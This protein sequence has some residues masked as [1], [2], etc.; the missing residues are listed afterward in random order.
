MTRRGAREGSIRQR[1]D[2]RWEA[3]YPGPDGNRRSVYGATRR[4]AQERLRDALASA[5][6]GLPVVDGRLTTGAY[7]E[8]WVAAART[9]V[10]PATASSYAATVKLYLVPELGRVP[11]A[12]LGPEHVTSMLTRLSARKL[13]VRQAPDKAAGAPDRWEAAWRG[14]DGGL[15]SVAA[16]T[17]AEAATL[18][19]AA[20]A[21]DGGGTQPV[22]SSTSVR[23]VYTVLRIALGRALKAGQVVR[24]V[25]TLVDPPAKARPQLTPLS[26][27]QVRQLL[28]A[29]SDDRLGPLYATAV[30]LGL[31]QGELL[32]LRWSDIE[33]D[34][35]PPTLA[36]RRQKPQRGRGDMAEPKTERARR[37]LVIPRAVVTVLREQRRRQRL[38]RLAHPGKPWEADHVF[39]TTAGRPLDSRNVLRAFQEAVAA[40]G[41]PHQRFHD[42]RHACA[43]LLLEQGEDLDVVSRI[44]GHANLSTTA[45][46][47]AHLTRGRQQRAADRMDAVLRGSGTA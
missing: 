39:T 3:R 20:I 14:P 43:T 19:R 36:V 32:G 11:L 42:L 21:R 31:R 46:V 41:L 5:D 4:E 33:L 10:R 30:G 44:L 2:G 18:A 1:P 28:E 37:S 8:T 45:D 23:Y 22:L 6:A 9:R 13:V 27:G 12:K 24:N 29:T 16:A 38:E 17:E 15:R 35:S 7:L 26:A 47:Y 25:A 40:A 34:A